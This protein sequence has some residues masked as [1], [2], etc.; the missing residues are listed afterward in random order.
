[1]V[2]VPRWI[3]PAGAREGHVLAVRHE[4]EESGSRLVIE[5]DQAAGEEALEESRRQ[6]ADAPDGG[7]GDITL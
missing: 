2:T 1:V 5:V 6:L 4:R 7:R 3:L